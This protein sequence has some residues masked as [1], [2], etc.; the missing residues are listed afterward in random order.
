M[1]INGITVE[2]KRGITVLE[3]ARA[4]GIYIPTLCYHPRL[5]PVG[6]CRLCVVEIQNMRG[7]PTACTVPVSDGMVVRTETEALQ[8][9]RREILSFM[10]SEHPYSCLVC[11]RRVRCDDFQGTVRKAAVTTGCQYCPKGGRCEIP[12]LVDYL[13]LRHIPYR[14]FYRGLRVE[15]EDPFIDRDYNLCMHL[16]GRCVRVC[17][18]VRHSGVLAFV[19]RGSE[20]AVGTAF[21]RSL[22]KANCQFCG[23]CVDVCPT[24]AL[25][26]K[27]GK[28]EGVPT[29]VVPSVC[30]YCS[31][32]CAV[33]LEVKNGRVIRAIGHDD[34]PTN[35]GQ[36]CVRGRFGV[37]DVVH[38]QNRLKAP[39]VRRNGRLVE[40]SWDEALDVTAQGLSQYR[41]DQFAVVGSAAATNEEDYV[42]QKFARAVM[43]SNNVALAAGFPDHDGGGELAD[44]LRMINGPAIREIRNAACILVIGANVFDSHPI[45][46]LEIRHA[47]SKGAHLITV[48]TRQINMARQSDLWLQPKIGTDHI[49]LAGMIKA[50][51][52]EGRAV[53]SPDLADLELATV[54][55]ITRVDEKAIVTAANMLAEH[56]PVTIIYGSGVTHYPTALAVIKA[57]RSLSFLVGDGGIIGV[58]GEGNFVGAHDMGVHP[59]LLPGYHPSSSSDARATFETAWG[60]ALSPTPGRTYEHILDGVRQREIKALYL[61]GEV[62]RLG[63]LAKLAFLVVQD[64]VPTK[65][66]QYAHV[67]LPATTFAEMDGTLTNLEGRVQRIRK[68]IPPVGLSRPGWMIVRDIAERMGIARWNY[69]LAADV[70]AEIA[71]LIPAYKQ[72][73]YDTLGVG[74]A[75]RR[76]GPA[77]KPQFVPFSLDEVPQL[78]TDE[79]PLTLITERNL[80]YYHGASLTE[81]VK[82]MNL[83]KNE[84]VLQLSPSDATRLRITD[85]ATVKVE[86]S[87]GSAECVVQA[88][89]GIPE[90]TAFIS[91]N[92]VT[93]SALFPNPAPSTKACAIRIAERSRM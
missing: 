69:N 64:I 27:R 30:P 33:N 9:L 14:I 92:R 12:K 16:C 15:Q 42:L 93:G 77:T 38:N 36:L 35:A 8:D 87:Y 40:A 18:D 71:S 45:I 23:A 34:G 72:L 43:H 83:I 54:A 37:V 86:S 85:G 26:D 78:A 59:A 2:T 44:T 80:F 67:V 41:E 50:L 74:G 62:P 29:G 88:T 39:L 1:T 68:V 13:R 63:E 19:Y 4:Y 49:L 3:A 17:Q 53:S 58:P 22:L 84:E 89:S 31:V 28:W 61:A 56:T 90:G 66:L 73:R 48:D 70:M 5:A 24:G 75:V 47:L 32:G 7:F 79:F 6:A 60:T 65:N 20:A 81:Q 52:G 57:I 11:E 51:A 10:L 76:F 46:G 21:G 91:I 55:A 25:A 82:G